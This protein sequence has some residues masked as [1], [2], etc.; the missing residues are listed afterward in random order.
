MK[1]LFLLLSFCGLTVIA[2]S[3][4]TWRPILSLT[5]GVQVDAKRFKFNLWDVNLGVGAKHFLNNGDFDILFNFQYSEFFPFQPK[6]VT[7]N[8]FRQ[9]LVGLSMNYNFLDYTKRVRPFIQFGALTEI[10]SNY[11]NKFIDEEDHY[12][13]SQHSGIVMIYYSYFYYSTPIL[14]HFSVGMNVLLVKD[15]YFTFSLGYGYKYQR[16]KFFKWDL[17]LGETEFLEESEEPG[18]HHHYHMLTAKF[19]FNYTIPVKKKASSVE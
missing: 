10:A 9:Q 6:I 1:N 16:M 14:A 2:S 19:G 7:A 3:Q 8:E 11:R 18:L 17:F 5:P 15:W 4:S 12:P 13:T